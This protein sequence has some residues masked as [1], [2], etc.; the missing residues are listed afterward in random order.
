MMKRMKGKDKAKASYLKATGKVESE[1]R[2]KTALA[3][4]AIIRYIKDYNKRGIERRT[5]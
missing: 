3:V 2:D 1:I 4:A 5:L